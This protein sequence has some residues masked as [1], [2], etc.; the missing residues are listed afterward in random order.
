MLSFVIMRVQQSFNHFDEYGFAKYNRDNREVKLRDALFLVHP[1]AKDDAQQALF[2][3]I[4][5]DELEVPYTWEVELSVLGQQSFESSEEKEAAV[6]AKWEELI[7]NNALGYMALLRNLRNILQAKVSDAHISSVCKRL[8]DPES[9]RKSKQFPFRFLSAYKEVKEVESMHTAQVLSALERAVAATAPLLQG[10]DEHTR[11]V[12]ASDVSG[13][14]WRPVSPKSKV[15]NYDIGILL[16]M[17]LKSHCHQ[18]YSG[19]FGDTW[20]VVNMPAEGIFANTISLSNL[21]NQVGFST[22]GYKVI[23]WLIE[24]NVI[25]DKVMMFTDCQMWNSHDNDERVTFHHSWKKYKAMA[26]EAKLYLFD[27]CG[28]GQSPVSLESDDVCLIAG[29]SDK[30]FDIL[31]AIEHGESAL[32]TIRNIEI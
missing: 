1:K 20:K 3:K 11:V 30:I 18:V 2:D 26:P 21:N 8:A 22:N 9:V 28:Y 13:S 29:W 14:M 17:L 4:A 32:D 19:I 16:S 27:L 25:T 6:R 12:L 23:D 31:D 10:F 15:Q 24:N 5:K 7:A